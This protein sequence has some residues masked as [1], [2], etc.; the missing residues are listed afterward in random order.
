[1][2]NVTLTLKKSGRHIELGVEQGQLFR[3]C[4][5]MDLK[6]SGLSNLQGDDPSKSPSIE[7]EE[8]RFALTRHF[9]QGC[10]SV[11]AEEIDGDIP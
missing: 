6:D 7:R 3:V 8:E 4:Q 10:T 5:Y 2:E 1:V 11:I 9:D